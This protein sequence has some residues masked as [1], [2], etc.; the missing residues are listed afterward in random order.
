MA[1]ILNVTGDTT[2]LEIKAA[3][4]EDTSP[5]VGAAVGYRPGR[6][7]RLELF[8]IWF[9]DHDDIFAGSLPL[10]IQALTNPTSEGNL[11]WIGASAEL[12][13][14]PALFSMVA[15]YQTGRFTIEDTLRN[16]SPPPTM[17]SYKYTQDV[18]AYFIDMS[19]EGNVVEWASLG[20]FCFVASGDAKRVNGPLK[21]A[22]GINADNPRMTI[23]F[24]PDFL[25]RDNEDRFSFSGVTS[26]GVIAP[27][28]GL[29]LQPLDDLT[30][31]V[32]AATFFAQEALPSGEQWYGYEIDLGATVRLFEQH[33]LFVDVAR[34][35][36]GDYFEA[37]LGRSAAPDPAM[38]VVIG[39]RLVF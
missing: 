11:Y 12:F 32:S 10:R 37:W 7:E 21:A 3:Q 2:Y 33:A 28:I 20:A 30:V 23:F 1:A 9:S 38:R 34:F 39:A 4:V 31:D 5:M 6:F 27:G 18:D 19:L 13:A 29:T 24:D 22:I 17:L 8:G 14:G 35:E 25:D 36:H 26:G 15:A 16:A